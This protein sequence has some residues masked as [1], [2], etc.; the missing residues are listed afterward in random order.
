MN[1]LITKNELIE[2][3]K[4]SG[5]SGAGGAG[6]PTYAKI[7][8][9]I[10]TII[11]NCAECE[12]LLKVHRQL[13]G[14]Y[15]FEII[16]TLQRIAETVNAKEVIIGIKEAYRE[17]VLAVE[18]ELPS[19]PGIRIHLLPEVYP[20][21]DEVIMIYEAT[22]KVVAPGSIP[23]ESGIAVFNVETI[24]NVYHA[25]D[26]AAP[27]IYKYLS[28]VGEVSNPVTVKV[29]IGMEVEQVVALAGQKL[30]KEYSY[31]MG[32]PM[33]GNI[34]TGYDVITK[35]TNA[36]LVLP[37]DHFV[38]NKKNSKSSIDMKRAMA[39]CCQCEMC[40]DLCPR[41]LLGHPIEPHEFMRAATSGT[42]RDVKPF[43]DT[44]YCSSC[45]L[46]E[47]YSCMQGLSPR[48][49]ITEYK[50]GLASNGIR[51]QKGLQPGKVCEVREYRAVP[52]D[53]LISRIGLKKYNVAAPLTQEQVECNLVKIKW[54]Q[55]IGAPSV[56]VV[57]VGDHVCRGQLLGEAKKDSLSLPV[58][59]SIEGTVLEI[60]EYFIRIQQKG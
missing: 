2:A 3:I 22:G 47:M 32:G 40:T 21:G 26:M 13:L 48:N 10:D 50:R 7:D 33:T 16:S 37:K 9:R 28:I 1:E 53:R 38:I 11:L 24:L 44:M 27:V 42:T 25:L 17:T 15:A 54:S 34:V 31:I 19:F 56:P 36:I 35:T 20:A 46:C 45:G 41:Y 6:F 60:N 39:S 8:D 52:I 59:S 18:A 57:K 14:T 29:P 23:I 5:I 58:H 12:P 30:I 4:N 55:H 43:L 51:P 49:L